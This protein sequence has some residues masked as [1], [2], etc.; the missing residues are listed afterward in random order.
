MIG[1]VLREAWRALQAQGGRPAPGVDANPLLDYFARNEGRLIFKWQ[2]YFDI[3]HRHF[4]AFRGRAPVVLEIGVFHGGSLQMWREYFGPG[5]RIVGIDLDPRCRA[6]AEDGIE[7]LIGDQAD[8]GFLASVR[9]RLPRVDILIDDGGH[10]MHQQITSFEELYPHVQPEGVYLCEDLHTSYMPQYDGGLQRPGT[11][12]ERAKTLVD[13]LHAWHSAEPERFA[14][15][16]L[17]RSTYA[18]HFYDSILVVEKRPLAPPQS[19][20]SGQPSF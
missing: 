17:T 19:C 5:S 9:D 8:R 3:Y 4:A 16:D 12:I 18:L 2:H 11:F 14:V 15:D 10:F 6:F 1:R 7:V 13:R 20:W